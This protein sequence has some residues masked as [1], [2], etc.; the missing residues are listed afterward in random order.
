MRE[1][2]SKLLKEVNWEYMIIAFGLILL[3]YVIGIVGFGAEF[4]LSGWVT[5]ISS[6][7][8]AVV[9][10]QGLSAYKKQAH[11]QI[12][13]DSA[14]DIINSEIKK[15]LTNY[16]YLCMKYVDAYNRMIENPY[17]DAISKAKIVNDLVDYYS[18]YK[19]LK[20]KIYELSPIVSLLPNQDIQLKYSKIIEFQSDTGVYLNIGNMGVYSLGT[21]RI[22]IYDMVRNTLINLLSA[23]Y[24]DRENVIHEILNNKKWDQI[25]EKGNDL[26]RELIKSAQ[27]ITTIRT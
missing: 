12:E 3:G 23:D 2:A 13:L 7:V 18:E 17:L 27:R 24:G 5:S 9:A 11:Y 1:C 20:E 15:D 19:V 21:E 4:H 10:I 16:G 14:K 22:A 8:V 25:Y 6:I 26:G